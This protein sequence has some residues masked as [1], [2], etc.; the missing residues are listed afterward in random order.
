MRFLPL[1]FIL[2]SFTAE[3]RWKLDINTKN[4]EQLYKEADTRAELE[5]F[6]KITYTKWGQIKWET[7]ACDFYIEERVNEITLKTEY[8]CPDTFSL[9]FTDITAGYT[10][11]L[12]L[13][14]LGKDVAFGKSVISEARL[15]SISNGWDAPTRIALRTLLAPAFM[16]FEN[17]DICAGYTQVNDIEENAQITADRKAQILALITAGGYTCN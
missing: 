14:Q 8:G 12:A 6:A 9:T 17:G 10:K 4:S 16:S 11:Q 2:I 3:A 5:D 15:L 1:L 7:V 13:E